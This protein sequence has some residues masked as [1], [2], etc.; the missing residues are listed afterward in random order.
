MGSAMINVIL[1]V[2]ILVEAVRRKCH[3]LIP[4]SVLVLLYEAADVGWIKVSEILTMEGTIKKLI[5]M[6]LVVFVFLAWRRKQAPLPALFA[7]LLALGGRLVWK[8][9]LGG[10]LDA[11][12]EPEAAFGALIAQGAIVKIVLNGVTGLMLLLMLIVTLVSVRK[13]PPESNC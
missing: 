5:L 1:T 9:V 10:Y 2:W 11:L 8:P 6:A 4:V 7:S 12:Q 3:R 13:A